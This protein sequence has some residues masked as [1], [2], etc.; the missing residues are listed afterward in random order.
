MRALDAIL[1][2]INGNGELANVSYGT[3]VGRTLQHYRD[4]PLVKMHYGQS[5]ALWH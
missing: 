5:L 3:N 2:N 1:G 4:I